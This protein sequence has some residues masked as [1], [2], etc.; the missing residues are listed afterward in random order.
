MFLVKL[1]VESVGF[2][3]WKFIVWDKCVIGMGYYYCVRY[4]F[5][6]FF[7]KGKRKLN[8]LSVFD[9]LEYKRVWKGYLIEKLV[10]F[11]EVLIR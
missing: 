2:K 3:F 8:D 1:I 6:L 10:E 4:E 9:V 5:I 7:E 11:L